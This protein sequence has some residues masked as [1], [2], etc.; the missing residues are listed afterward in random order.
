MTQRWF[1]DVIGRLIGAFDGSPPPTGAIECS[2]PPA[3]D[4]QLTAD[5]WMMTA[6]ARARVR[7]HIDTTAELRRQLVITPGAG[8]ALVYERK[9]AQAEHCLENCS[10]ETPPPAGRYRLLQ[11]DVGITVE[12]SGDIG[13]DVLTIARAVQALAVAWEDYA[14]AI[15]V[16]RLG[17]KRAV[18]AATTAAA[19]DAVLAGIV[20]PAP[21]E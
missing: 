1:V 3:G 14:A 17:A 13:A 16:A 6:A 5:G 2:Q 19:V 15:E 20:W 12:D 4:L 11:A 18:D 10:D 21:P 7:Q 9:R 8:Q